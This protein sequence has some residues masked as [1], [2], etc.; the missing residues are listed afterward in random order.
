MVQS[1]LLISVAVNDKASYSTLLENHEKI[2][3]FEKVWISCSQPRTYN[4]IEDFTNI[5]DSSPKFGT[6][7]KFCY[8]VLL[9]E[10]FGMER[11][12]D[13]DV[14]RMARGSRTVIKGGK[15]WPVNLEKIFEN[16]TIH[17]YIITPYD[18]TRVL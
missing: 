11:S 10:E 16:I 3:S 5:E 13:Y 2:V 12:G 14:S 7:D 15:N 9:Y 18:K 1:L 4:K 8:F 17:Q 6:L